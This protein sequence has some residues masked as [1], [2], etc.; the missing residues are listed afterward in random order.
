MSQSGV[1]H[2]VSDRGFIYTEPIEGTDNSWVQVYESSAAAAFWPRR[3]RDGSV[4]QGEATGPFIWV[5]VSH[6]AAAHL[7]LAAAVRLR[8]AL[9]FLI[10]EA[11]R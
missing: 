1:P 9:S 5:R 4:E 6:E 10:S 8:D 2:T 3:L 7:P 11:E